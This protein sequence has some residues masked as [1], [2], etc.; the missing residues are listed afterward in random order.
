LE[1]AIRLQEQDLEKSRLVLHTYEAL[2]E[3][4]ESLV[5]E[6]TQLRLAADNK[7][8]ALQ[9]LSKAQR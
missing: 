8:W 5:R 6:Y 7:R 1:G 9:E 3:D 4:F 2:G